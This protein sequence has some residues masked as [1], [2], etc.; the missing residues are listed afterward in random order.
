MPTKTT[1][2]GP[3]D[4]RGVLAARI[5]DEA[6]ASFAAHGYAGTTVRAV[7]RA[8]DVDPALVYHY[9]DSKDGLL[10]AATTPPQSFLD[11]I[12]AAWQTPEAE[13][14]QRLV[15]DMLRNWEDPDHGPIL[16]AVLQ[17][18]GSESATREK[19]RLI[20]ERSMMGPSAHALDESERLLRSSLIASQF[21]G[22]AFMRY[23]WQIEPL[24]S[25]TEDDIVAAIAPT[26]QRYLTGDIV[27]ATKRPPRPGRDSKSAAPARSR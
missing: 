7:A 5:L 4:E 19:L 10:D 16:R 2:P 11:R 25:M 24:A 26:I 14:G 23:L 1:T 20:I 3:R 18:A 8:A 15:R 13:L 17:I 12:V 22:L 9:Y 21:M 6:R 27:V